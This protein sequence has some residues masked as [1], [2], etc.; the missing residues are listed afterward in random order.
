MEQAAS[1][2]DGEIGYDSNGSRT[3]TEAVYAQ[4]RSDILWGRLSAGV[5]LRSD[6]LRA[7]YNVGISPLREALNRL[8]GDGLVVASGQ[9]GFRV[10]PLTIEDVDDISSAR[11]VIECAALA[12]SIDRGSVAWETNVFTS[13]RRLKEITP[14]KLGR[15]AQVW[16]A[17]HK[18]FHFAL[19]SMCGSPSLLKVAGMLFDQAERYRNL[20]IANA[21]AAG[22]NRLPEHDD[23]AHAAISRDKKTATRLLAEHYRKTSRFIVEHLQE[24][25]R[26][27][28]TVKAPGRRNRRSSN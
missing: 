11:I 3:L 24:T 10:P 19:L 13:L 21:M 9:R 14:Q 18:E 27:P 23:I 26:A 12:R 4:L 20:D 8:I 2:S 16:A 25:M 15:G 6:D 22:R 5:P 28:A 17:R 7:K 1:K